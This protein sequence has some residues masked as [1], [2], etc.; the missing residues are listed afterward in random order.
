MI[1]SL[2]ESKDQE[3]YNIF[4]YLIHKVKPNIM[5]IGYLPGLNIN[6]S[7]ITAAGY[8]SGSYQSSFLHIANSDIIKG[9]GLLNGSLYSVSMDDRIMP[10]NKS[11]DVVK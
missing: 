9:S 5:S 3:Y 6:Q 8:S 10:G 2:K 4:L 11:D 1:Y 7:L